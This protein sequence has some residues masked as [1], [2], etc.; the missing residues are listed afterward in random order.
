LPI[1]EPEP[2]EDYY[3]EE[4]EEEEYPIFDEDFV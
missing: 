4:E 2:K 1:V 3:A